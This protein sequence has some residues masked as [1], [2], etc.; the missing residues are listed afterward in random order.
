MTDGQQALLSAVIGMGCL[1]SA[2]SRPF[3]FDLVIGV[4]IG[5]LNLFGAGWLLYVASRPNHTR[6]RDRR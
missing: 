5:G 2:I 3:G 1:L 6:E 4:I